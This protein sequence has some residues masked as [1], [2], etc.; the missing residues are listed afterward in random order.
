MNENG[1]R[2]EDLCALIQLAIGGSIFPHKR[3]H[4]ATW[5]SPHHVTEYQIDN[6]CISSK[7]RRYG[8]MYE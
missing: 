6:I 8:G 7:F 1:E 4:K 5:I 3:I 2:F